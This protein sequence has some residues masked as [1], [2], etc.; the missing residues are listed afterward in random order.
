MRLV[1]GVNNLFLVSTQASLATRYNDRA[2]LE[3]HHCAA[4]FGILL[5][6]EFNFTTNFSN[7]EFRMFRHLV[8]T[9]I[10]A[11]DMGVHF[12]KLA[13]FKALSMKEG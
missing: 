12:S 9:C 10:M 7:E 3:S 8:I 13:Q 5:N 2:P 4:T 11:T 6:D 1:R